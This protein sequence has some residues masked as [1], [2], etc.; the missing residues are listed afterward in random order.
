MLTHT[1]LTPHHDKQ[2][3]RSAVQKIRDVPPLFGGQTD[4]TC[5]VGRDKARH[6][7]SYKPFLCVVGNVTRRHSAQG[8]FR[9]TL[10]LCEKAD[11]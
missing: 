5:C 3:M 7:T 1:T 11:R 6:G 8:N 2:R 4:C 9:A 10:L